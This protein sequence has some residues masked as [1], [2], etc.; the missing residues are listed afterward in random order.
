MCLALIGHLK[1]Q[2]ALFIWRESSSESALRV[3]SCFEGMGCH[4]ALS[5]Q[6]QLL[7]LNYV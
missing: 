6:L 1:T 4:M 7:G 2:H 3:V 5:T